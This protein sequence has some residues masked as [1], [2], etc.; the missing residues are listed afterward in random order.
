MH[1]FARLAAVAVF[2]LA[3][4]SL[5]FPTAPAQ[6]VDERF[7]AQLKQL[8][9]AAAA[10][11]DADLAKLH[12]R[13]LNL[14]RLTGGT[15]TGVKAAALLAQL[16]SALDR[17]D[18]NAIP[19]IEKFSW[20]PKELVAILGEH[21]GRHGAAVTCV[22]ISPDGK[23]IA[24][25]GFYY[26]RLWDPTTMR[27]RALFSHGYGVTC[28]AFS[29]DSQLLA[30]GNTVG[31]VTVWELKPGDTP[32]VRKFTSQAASTPIHDVV[33][34]PNGKT[35]ACACGDNATRLF[36]ISGMELKEQAVVTGHTAAVMGVAYSPDGKILATGS[37]D[38][39]I[40]LWNATTDVPNERLTLTGPTEGVR[41]LAFN[42]AGSTIAAGCNDGKILFYTVGQT[43]PRTQC[44][45]KDTGAVNQLSYS[46]TGNTIAAACDDAT[47]RLWTV[48]TSPPRERAKLDGHV[49]SV[50]SVAYAP[51]SRLLVSGGADWMVRTWDTTALP[52]PKERFVPTAHLG[53]TYSTDFAPDGTKL[54]S[55]SI[56]GTTRVWDLDRPDPKTRHYLPHGESRRGLHQIFSV[57]ISP[58]SKAVAFGGNFKTIRQYDLNTGRPLRPMVNEHGRNDRIVYSPNGKYLLAAGHGQKE[59]VLFDAETGSLDRTFGMHEV[60]INCIAFSPDGKQIATGS[61]TYLYD[62][63]GKIVLD[64]MNR[65]VYNDCTIKLWETDTAKELHA[66]KTHKTPIYTLAF[67]PDARGLFSSAYEG[68]LR[69]RNLAD[70]VNSE[71]GI[72]QAEAAGGYAFGLALSRDG[73][74]AVTAGLDH[75]IICWDIA[76]GKRL[77]EWATN[78]RITGVSLASDG[79]H[80]AVPLHT[81]VVYVIRLSPSPKLTT[82]K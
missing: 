67:T 22:G 77:W 82:Q 37:Q 75:R 40:K 16:P 63:A 33:F 21:R 73:K 46:H 60:G 50:A 5:T 15:P 78:E 26:L 3:G 71:A 20:Q 41:C 66:L 64:K 74:R 12:P 39:T 43:K 62:Q 18:P 72:F 2:S 24:S 53:Y 23:T 29:R 19:E 45:G 14:L 36:D 79:R 32:P 54:A 80:I 6:E 8:T 57:A 1:W 49:N 44:V 68:M 31:S 11:P 38:K 47:V 58:D 65:Y 30:A 17:L 7:E 70:P 55:G 9:E 56:D 81:G 25:G 13:V 76:S 48:A 27:L 61:G 69:Q 28:L 52:T 10:A 35:I 34:S 59:A 4:L 42:P 51:D